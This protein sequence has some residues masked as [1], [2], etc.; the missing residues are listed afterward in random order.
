MRSAVI[1]SKRTTTPS[2]RR[3]VSTL[4][5]AT[6]GALRSAARSSRTATGIVGLAGARLEA[7]PQLALEPTGADD[8]HRRHPGGRHSDHLA[9]H[10]VGELVHPREELVLA[11]GGDDQ[12]VARLRGARRAS[13]ARRGCSAR[14]AR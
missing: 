11:V 9:E 14:P 12:G 2:G 7:A 3:S 5:F 6:S 10:P 8:L 13:P 1:T 4:A